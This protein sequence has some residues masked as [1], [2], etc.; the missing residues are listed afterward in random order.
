VRGTQ[1]AAFDGVADG[2]GLEIA[3]LAA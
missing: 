2:H 3:R 1:G